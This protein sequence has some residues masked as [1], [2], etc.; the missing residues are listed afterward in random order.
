[1]KVVP[2][3]TAG[4]TFYVITS[5]TNSV[6]N[7]S[8]VRKHIVMKVL[9]TGIV[10]IFLTGFKPSPE[11]G[12]LV[13]RLIVQPSSKLTIDGKTNVNAFQCAIT[14]YVGRDTLVLREGRNRRPVFTQGFVGLNA[15]TFD[16]GMQM[17]THDFRKTIKSKEFPVV[18]IEFISF[19]RLP[20]YGAAEAFKGKM[21]ISLAGVTKPFEM[22]CTIETESS[23]YIHLKGSRRFTFADFNLEPPSHMMGLVKVQDALDV[24]FHLVLLLDRNS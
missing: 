18:S 3:T 21:K 7:V 20:K 4:T 9:L 12:E 1:M 17:M 14:Q 13:H 2:V 24:S 19:E 11:K 5:G 10:F 16:C 22:T 23:G 8:F 6:N 15:A